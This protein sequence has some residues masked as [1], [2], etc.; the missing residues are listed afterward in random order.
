MINVLVS[1]AAG[2]MGRQVVGA[3]NEA[4]GLDCVGL[5]DQGPIPEQVIGLVPN[6]ESGDSLSILFDQCLPDVMVDFTD[7][8]AGNANILQAIQAGVSTVIGTTGFSE[9]QI[10][11]I[12]SQAHAC[13]IGVFMAPNFAL[14]AV[15]LMQLA[16]VASSHFDHAE[17][18][19]LHHNNKKD[20]PSGTAMETARRMLEARGRP[21]SDTATEKFTLESARGGVLGGLNVHSV[22][23]PGMVAHQEVIFGGLGQT[24]SLRHDST[25]RESFMPGV[26]LAVKRVTDLN[27]LVIGLEKLLFD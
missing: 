20:A 19:E 6:A 10:E 1:G 14:G 15:M 12:S 2:N 26:I 25:S 16:S 17:I 22:R 11:E 9:E 21:F 7:A 3:L 18:I 23:L 24:L 8:S 13:E 4:D 5:F 27:G